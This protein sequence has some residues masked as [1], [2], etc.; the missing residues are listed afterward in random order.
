MIPPSIHPSLPHPPP[1]LLCHGRDRER[2]RRQASKQ[3]GRSENSRHQ[4]SVGRPLRQVCVCVSVFLLR[5]FAPTCP[6]DLCVCV[7][8]VCV[9]FLTIAVF[10]T[11]QFISNSHLAIVQPLS[12]THTH[13]ILFFFFLNRV[14]ICLLIQLFVVTFG[15]SGYL[16]QNNGLQVDWPSR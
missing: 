8:R 7:G 6:S 10:H 14:N 1:F 16:T 12:H 9:F 11:S 5:S 3:A 15:F 13:T 4:S 2:E